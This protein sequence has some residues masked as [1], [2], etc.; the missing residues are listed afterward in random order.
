MRQL[1]RKS[2]QGFVGGE[3]DF[4]FVLFGNVKDVANVYITYVGPHSLFPL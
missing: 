3:N 1:S 2:W 4:V